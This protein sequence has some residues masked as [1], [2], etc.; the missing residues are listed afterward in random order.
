MNHFIQWVGE[1]ARCSGPFELR[2]EFTLNTLFDED[3]DGDIVGIGQR[4]DGGAFFGGE[5]SQN[6]RQVLFSDIELESDERPCVDGGIE[7]DGNI[8]D[9]MPLEV[10]I[11]CVV[12]GD[13][14]RGG[15]ENRIDDAEVVGLERRACFGQLDDPV[16]K[17]G[18]D[19]GGAP[20]ELD[21]NVDLL[22][23]E[24]PFCGVDQFRGDDAAGE[25]FGL[26]DIGFIGDG[27]N[28]ASR[29]EVALLYWS[30]QTWRTSEA[31][32]IIQS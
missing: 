29:L 21:F 3:F 8:L 4:G 6:R 32:S 26:L 16:D 15:D 11:P 25:V 1:D 2:D 14:P 22:F 31:F 24:I 23:L 19:L 20:T 12:I 13:E 18:L 9:L 5:K 7:E 27:Q 10:V 28:P 30:G 17:T